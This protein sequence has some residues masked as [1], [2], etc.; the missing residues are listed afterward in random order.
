MC[1]DPHPTRRQKIVVASI[2]CFVGCVLCCNAF[3]T[4]GW[5]TKTP[6]PA[7]K[8]FYSYSHKDEEIRNRLATYLAPVRQQNKILEWHDRK[9]EPGSNWDSEISDQLNSADLIL[10]FHCCA[11]SIAS[12]SSANC[13]DTLRRSVATRAACHCRCHRPFI[14]NIHAHLTGYPQPP[15][16]KRTDIRRRQGRG[17]HAGPP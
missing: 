13:A 16:T 2:P 8:V 1:T 17:Q 4:C 14:A 5:P 10:L 9:I 11:G 6:M 3:L 12:S 15:R 7:W